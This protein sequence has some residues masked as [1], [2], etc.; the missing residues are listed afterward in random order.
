MAPRLHQSTALN[1]SRDKIS[2]RNN[3]C[4]NQRQEVPPIAFQ[5]LPSVYKLLLLISHHGTNHEDGDDGGRQ[6]AAQFQNFLQ[7]YYRRWPIN[8]IISDAYLTL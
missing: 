8:M 5:A 4:L 7:S 1:C 6:V 2:P 3:V